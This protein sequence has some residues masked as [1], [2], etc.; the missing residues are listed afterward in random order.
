MSKIDSQ[1]ERWE[2]LMYAVNHGD[3]AKAIVALSA[4]PCGLSRTTEVTQVSLPSQLCF[5]S[6]GRQSFALPRR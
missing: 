5:L 6:P 3:L 2:K 4:G 1:V